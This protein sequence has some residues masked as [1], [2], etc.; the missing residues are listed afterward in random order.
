M[1]RKFGIAPFPKGRGPGLVIENV[2]RG[3]TQY[4]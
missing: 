2:E 1:L 3:K 4:E